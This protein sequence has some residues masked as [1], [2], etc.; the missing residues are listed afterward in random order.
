M[1][2]MKTIVKIKKISAASKNGMSIFHG[3]GNAVVG[4][5][6]TFEVL[7]GSGAF[8]AGHNEAVAIPGREHSFWWPLDAAQALYSLQQAVNTTNYKLVEKVSKWA[9]NCCPILCR[10]DL[11]AYG[12]KK[13]AAE[14]LAAE[15]FATESEAL[16][17]AEESMFRVFNLKAV[18]IESFSDVVCLDDEK[19]LNLTQ[20]AATA[21]QAEAGVVDLENKA[22]IQA[23]LTFDKIPTR[24]EMRQRATFLAEF[25]AAN[26]YKRA[27]IGGAPFFMS[28]LER[29]L[30][31]YGVKPVYAFSVRDSKEEPDGN[32]GVRKINV[33]KHVGFVEV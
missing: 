6:I 15:V 2:T 21:E 28:E 1:K 17:A 13:A 24:E 26:Y 18:E 19:I 31:H 12:S 30:R 16:D 32:G 8:Y 22:A 29:A 5:A 3:E 27:M 11:M 23:A 33:F 10:D 9:V 14:E 7:E 25:A 20:H 4:T